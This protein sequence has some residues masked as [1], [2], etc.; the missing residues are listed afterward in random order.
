MTNSCLTFKIRHLWNGACVCVHA[1]VR[2]CVEGEQ[3]R[4]NIFKATSGHSAYSNIYE[5]CLYLNVS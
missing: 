3:R 4:L 1:C 5:L 2:V